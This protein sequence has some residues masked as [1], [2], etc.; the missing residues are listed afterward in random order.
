MGGD[1][2]GRLKR[3]HGRL[4]TVM[5]VIAGAA[6]ALASS[7]ALAQTKQAP[8]NSPVGG[9]NWNP[10]VNVAPAVAGITLDPQ[11]VEIVNKVNGYFNKLDKLKG[12]F[13][14]TS[15]DKKRLKGKFYLLK[16][17]RIRFE[18]SLPSRQLVVSDGHQ[19]AIQDLDIN[20][21]DRVMVDQTPFR[22]LLRKDVD[23]LRDARI[24]EV[25]EADDLLIVALQDK[26][27]DSNGKI[28]LFLAKTP[29][30][31]LKEWVTTDNQGLDT[32]VEVSN[33]DHEARVEPVLFKITSPQ[34]KNLQ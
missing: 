9:P 16:P 18:Y 12:A 28:R 19:I 15:P 32:R 27:Q 8:P 1:L 17:G 31:E 14:Q 25:Q 24:L 13:V 22:V 23:L 30:L 33:L 20:T 2:M 4:E 29:T 3:M 21:D 11:Q 26:G 5:V 7:S 10:K 6:V 34:L